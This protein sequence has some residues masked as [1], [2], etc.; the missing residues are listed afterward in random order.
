MQ[1]N[2]MM[3]FVCMQADLTL[4]V[5]L[6]HWLGWT[7]FCCLMA[8][9]HYSGSNYDSR[10]SDKYNLK[11]KVYIDCLRQQILVSLKSN[12]SLNYKII[13]TVCWKTCYSIINALWCSFKDTEI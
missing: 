10:Y 11:D 7:Y 1:S 6:Q 12:G 13:L 4:T 9:L 8:Y 5:R 2:D 3:G